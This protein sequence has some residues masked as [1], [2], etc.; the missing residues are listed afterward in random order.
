MPHSTGSTHA[1]QKARAA[2]AI[3]LIARYRTALREIADLDPVEA[4]LDPQWS[5]R[6]AREALNTHDHWADS[7]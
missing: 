2:E 6:V 7:K 5:A 3:G 1:R 4:A